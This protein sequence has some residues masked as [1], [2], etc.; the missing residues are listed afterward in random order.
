VDEIGRRAHAAIVVGDW[1]TLR[2]L[3]PY[4]RW[5]DANGSTLRG[6][7]QVIAMLEQTAETRPRQRPSSCGMDR[8]TGGMLDRQGTRTRALGVRGSG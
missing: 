8:Y 5:A 7:S 2:P 3:H 1:N 4:L 6:R